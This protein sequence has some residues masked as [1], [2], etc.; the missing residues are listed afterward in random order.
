MENNSWLHRLLLEPK[1]IGVDVDSPERMVA[2]REI[3]EE[4]PVLKNVFHDFH[5]QIMRLDEKYFDGGEG[6]RIELGAGVC[7]IKESYPD[8]LSTDVVPS[9]GLDRVIDAQNMDVDDCS[10]RAIYGQNC[11]HHFPDPSRFFEELQRVLV[12]GGG[13]ILI[14]PYHGPVG[15]FL[16]KRLF[17]SEGFDKHADSWV[18][19]VDGPMNGANQA[20]S[21]LVFKRDRAKF[22]KKFDRLE[23]VCDKPLNNYIRYL[24]SGG[25][26]FRCLAP[27]V[28]ER[29]IRFVELLLKPLSRLLALHY[30]IVI[31]RKS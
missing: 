24:L 12:P 30:I 19:E 22:E 13:A 8:V 10:V 3:L 7:P 1:I 21:Y 18:T 31:R 17:S 2:H 25:L 5:H 15:S 14:E 26:N 27:R 16:F 23:I 9:D 6:L 20:L 29:P 4:K 28:L 11:F